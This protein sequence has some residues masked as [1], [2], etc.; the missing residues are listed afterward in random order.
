MT[1]S[2]RGSTGRD[3]GICNCCSAPSTF[4]ID[5]AMFEI[6]GMVLKAVA[7]DEL[8][9]ASLSSLASRLHSS[10]V[11]HNFLILARRSS[12]VTRHFDSVFAAAPLFE[13]WEADCEH[14]VFERGRR[15]VPAYGPAQLY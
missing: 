2:R 10:P 9:R 6:C 15:R 8:N 3:S 12:L 14:A 13:L 4:S 5:S 11:T 1:M 7:S